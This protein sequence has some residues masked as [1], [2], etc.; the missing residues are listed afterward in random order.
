MPPHH[1]R[2]HLVCIFAIFLSTSSTQPQCQTSYGEGEITVLVLA[3][4]SASM[5]AFMVSM[6]L[7]VSFAHSFVLFVLELG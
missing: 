6:P 2:L 7:L 3:E 1:C 4:T 5:A